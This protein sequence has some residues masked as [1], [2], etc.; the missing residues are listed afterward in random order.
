[1]GSVV[2]MGMA[3]AL[4]CNNAWHKHPMAGHKIRL[5]EDVMAMVAHWIQQQSKEL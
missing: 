1:M 5:D 2:H 4:P 3:V